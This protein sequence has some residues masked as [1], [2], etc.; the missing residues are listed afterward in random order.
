MNRLRVRLNP[1]GDILTTVKDLFLLISTED[2]DKARVMVES[3]RSSIIQYYICRNMNREKIISKLNTFATVLMSN[4]R[5]H[6]HLKKKVAFD[7]LE[8]ILTLLSTEDVKKTPS[9]KYDHLMQIYEDLQDD[10][11][12]FARLRR[13]EDTESIRGDFADIREM[14][15]RFMTDDAEYTLYQDLVRQIGLCTGMLLRGSFSEKSG[16]D[17]KKMYVSF[18]NLF[19]KFESL[20]ASKKFRKVPKKDE[21]VSEISDSSIKEIHDLDELQGMNAEAIAGHTGL[22]QEIVESVLFGEE[23]K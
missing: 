13:Y 20:I 21:E 6:R 3:L 15:P 2:F 14:E 4:L 9:N 17:I 10:L 7:K 8:E 19:P 22:S 16:P 23:E 11:E 1:K 5:I 18:E 12:Q